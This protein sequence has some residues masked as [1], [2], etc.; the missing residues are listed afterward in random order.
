[1]AR[2]SQRPA[3]ISSTCVVFAE[4]EIVGMLA[5]QVPAEDIAAGVQ[6][7]I[8]SRV[9]AMAGLRVVSPVTFT[10]GA[11]LIS[12]M[13]TALKNALKCPVQIAAE[14]QMTGSLGA[15]LS[16]AKECGYSARI[17]VKEQ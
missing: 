14:P 16:A 7:A 13:D 3:K 5:A 12:G 4:T 6:A 15:A 10:G 1:M 9:A 11:A 17:R 8:A 2:K